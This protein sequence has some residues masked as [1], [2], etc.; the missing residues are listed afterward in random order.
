MSRVKMCKRCKNMVGEHNMSDVDSE[1]C[2]TC[3]EIRFRL[4]LN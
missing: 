1:Y 3:D 4:S 2:M